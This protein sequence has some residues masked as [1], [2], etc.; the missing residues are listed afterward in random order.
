MVTV[1]E[2]RFRWAVF[3]RGLH[4]RGGFQQE[5]A[6]QTSW[7]VIVDLVCV[8]ITVWVA[9]GLYMWWGVRGHRAWG[10]LAILAGASSFAVFT[11]GL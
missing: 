8:A 7:S 10:L 5:G 1:E 3:F 2:R 4:E 9:S 11:F 6:L